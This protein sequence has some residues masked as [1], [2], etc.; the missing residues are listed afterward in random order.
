MQRRLIQEKEAD[1]YSCNYCNVVATEVGLAQNT[2]FFHK[3]KFISPTAPGGF[4]PP[5]LC[6]RPKS[7]VPWHNSGQYCFTKNCVRVLNPS[8][9]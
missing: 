4:G 1:P 6:G 3:T 8:A 9:W 5:A 2:I 7:R